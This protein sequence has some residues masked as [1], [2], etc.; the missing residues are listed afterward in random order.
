[1][2][3]VPAAQQTLAILRTLAVRGACSASTLAADLRLPRSTTYH[4]LATLRDSGFVIHRESER[5]WSLGPSAVEVG[6]AALRHDP[7]EAIARPHLIKLATTVNETAHL[8]VLQ[9]AEVLYL[10]KETPPGR[11]ESPT[12][13][14]AVGV[15]LPATTT[16]SGRAILAHL[17]F[18]QVRALTATPTAFVSRTGRGPSSLSQ[19]RS[20]LRQEAREGF[21]VEVG[22]IMADHASVAAAVLDARGLPTA[23]VSVTVRC[24]ETEFADR[25]EQLASAVVATAARINSAR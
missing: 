25:R 21:S 5:R 23:A 3:S 24:D 14:T 4:L 6:M 20:V 15:R 11:T 17:P 19:L 7:R 1:M 2:S 16:A 13:I 10:L 22:E 18:A 9:G 8:G 12:L